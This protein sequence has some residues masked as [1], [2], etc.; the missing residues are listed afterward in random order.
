VFAKTHRDAMVGN[1]NFPT[2]DP[3][4]EVFDEVVG[5][6]SAK[7]AQIAMKEV[8]LQTLRAER[9]DLR[10]HVDRVLTDR[11]EYVQRVSGGDA[12]KIL[13]AAF[14]VQAEPTP[15]TSIEKPTNVVATMG[16]EEGEV[17]VSWHAVGKAKAYVIQC[18]EHSDTAAPGQWGGDRFGT[19]SSI[20]FTDLISG[21]KY[22]FRVKAIGPNELESAWSDEVICMAP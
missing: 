22:A 17:D 4:V 15:T 13:S 19:R 8:E 21:K 3:S 9:K 1:S 11:G 7:S 14:E 20:T 18:R 6:F 2:P 12:A 10:G 5:A 16:D